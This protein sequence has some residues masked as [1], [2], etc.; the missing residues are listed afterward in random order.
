MTH[1]RSSIIATLLA[2]SSFAAVARAQ[3]NCESIPKGPARTDCYLT[4]SELYR[5]QTDLATSKARVQSDAARLRQ[6][7]GTTKRQKL[8]NQE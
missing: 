5:A 4:S 7:T 8:K 1:W 6:V 2:V 3:V